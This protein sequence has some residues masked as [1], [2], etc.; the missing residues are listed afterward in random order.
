M[1]KKGKPLK[2]K[3]IQKT[4]LSPSPLNTKRKRPP[5]SSTPA[6]LS[7]KYQ[8]LK[9]LKSKKIILSLLAILIVVLGFLVAGAAYWYQCPQKNVKTVVIIE[10][11]SSLSQI[12]STLTQHHILDFP[13]LFKG[14]LLGTGQW[15]DLKAGEYLIPPSVTP[16]QVLYILISGN[17][18]L[19]PITLIEGETSHHLVQ[20]LRENPYFQGVCDVP[21]E[22]SLLP[23][24]Y[25]FPRGTSCQKIVI[26]MQKA[27]EEAIATIWSTRSKDHPLRSPKD[28]LILASIVEKETSFPQERPLVAAVFLNRLQQGMPL[29][30]DPTVIYAFTQ[31][32]GELG[33]DLSR[34]DLSVD[35][36]YNTYRNLSLPPSPIANPGIASLKAAANPADVSYIYFVANGS[37]GHIFATTL[38]EHQKNHTEWRRI[39]EKKE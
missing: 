26:R 3:G 36:P 6:P 18:I 30:A 35:S 19:H 38:Q 28:L 24:T 11:G 12:T 22:G 27:M 17:V 32:K 2:P 15:R 10:K 16:A 4:S 13:L 23:E 8:L 39:R 31:G 14:I 20:K 29:Q 9:C 1:P 37:G 25:H 21:P 7:K 5:P 33:R 34:Q